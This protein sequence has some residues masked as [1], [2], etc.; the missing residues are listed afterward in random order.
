[1]PTGQPSE[2]KLLPAYSIAAAARFVDSSTSTLRAWFRGRSYKVGGKS[3]HTSP[4]L[5]TS[6]QGNPISFI[7]LIEAHVLTLVRRE[8]GIPMKNVKAAAETLQKLK[9]SLRFLAHED[10]YADQKHLFL[11]IDDQLVSLSERGQHV[12]Q[13]IISKGLQQLNYGEDGFASRFYPAFRGVEQKDVFLDPEINFGRPCL[14]E[15][16]V[17]ANVMADR[18]FA[19]ETIANLAIDYGA[20]RQQVETALRWHDL[21]AA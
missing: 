19:G 1:M 21:Q 20:T 11:K 2:I 14:A 17:S 12:D 4:I 3:R 15:L 8:Y 9:G 13:Q 18:F 10:F 16:G 6:T 5:P 7:D